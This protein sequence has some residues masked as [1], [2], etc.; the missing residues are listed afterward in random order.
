MGSFEQEQ[1][2]GT[3]HAVMC[4]ESQLAGLGGLLSG[5]PGVAAVYEQGEAL[6]PYDLQCSLMSLPAAFRTG[7]DTVPGPG[8]YL[9]AR[10][11]RLAAWRDRLGVVPMGVPRTPP[12]ADGHPLRA[13]LPGVGADDFL[14]LWS[15]IKHGNAWRHPHERTGPKRTGTNG[16]GT[17]H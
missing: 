3:G 2:L 1:Q 17:V 9:A 8:P 10:P 13:R 5:L 14:L 11:D 16:A 7:L 15:S 6:P 4:G 12:R